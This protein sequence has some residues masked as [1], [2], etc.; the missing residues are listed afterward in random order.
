MSASQKQVELGFVNLSFYKDH[1][2]SSIK[3]GSVIEL[4][5]INAL[6]NECKK[7]FGDKPHI[8]ISIRKNNYNVNPLM[9]SLLNDYKALKGIAI[10][11]GKPQTLSTAIFES[12]F[13]HLPFKVFV[14]LEE[15]KLW[16]KNAI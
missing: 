16:V 14:N 13:A 1:V 11:T 8:Y 12:K 10:V 15:A 5:E 3:E 2:I 7:F 4:E 6:L 9:Y